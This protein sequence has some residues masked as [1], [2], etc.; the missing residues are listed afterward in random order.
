VHNEE[1]YRYYYPDRQ[2]GEKYSF[3]YVN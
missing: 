3:A 1:G 2:Y